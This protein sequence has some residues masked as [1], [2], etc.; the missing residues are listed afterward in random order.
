MAAG[1]GDVTE[2][3]LDRV[4]FTGDDRVLDVGCGNGWA[5]ERMRARGAGTAIGIDLSLSML[6]RA[7]G[8]AAGSMCAASATRLPF[9]SGIFSRV[10]SVESLYYYPD[11]DGALQEIRRV[12]AD[13]ARFLCIVDLFEEN[14]GSHGWVEVLAVEV[15]LLSETEYVHRFR[16][17]GFRRAEAVRLRDRRPGFRGTDFR[18]SVWFPTFQAYQAYREAGSL[19][20]EAEA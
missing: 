7:R 8:A 11:L 14:P 5:V 18:P 6:R 19:L 2:Q 20:I 15:H 9:P 16:A 4:P 3:A 17:A 13:G 1:H 10:L 12:C